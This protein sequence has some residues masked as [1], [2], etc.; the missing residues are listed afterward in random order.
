MGRITL[1]ELRGDLEGCISRVRRGERLLVA[2]EEA[3]LMSLQPASG[4]A[5]TLEA[6]LRDLEHEGVIRQ[7]VGPAKV[8]PPGSTTCRSR[9][10]ACWKRCWKSAAGAAESAR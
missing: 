4:E 7:P 10:R 3:E 1:D 6:R 5:R 9:A 2:E 8:E